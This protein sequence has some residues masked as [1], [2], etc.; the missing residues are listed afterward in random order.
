MFGMNPA[1]RPWLSVLHNNVPVQEV[2]ASDSWDASHIRPTKLGIDHGLIKKKHREHMESGSVYE[3][4]SW[5][6]VIS[7]SMTLMLEAGPIIVREGQCVLIVAG[8]RG[9]VLYHP[10]RVPLERIW[11]SIRGTLCMAYANL[12]LQR[13]GVIQNIG[14][15]ARSVQLAKQLVEQARAVTA[16]PA[17]YWSEQVFHFFNC[18]W[19]DAASQDRQLKVAIT[20]SKPHLLSNSIGSFTKF[21]QRLGYSRSHLTTVLKDHWQDTPGKLIRQSR[22]ERAAELLRTTRRSIADIAVE[23]GYANH[24]SFGRAFARQYA[25][26]P[27]RYRH[28][29][30]HSVP[31]FGCSIEGSAEDNPE[32]RRE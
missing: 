25:K 19:A 1:F 15:D 26:T 31:R 32:H 7:G 9:Q 16:H 22:L 5:Q 20:S 4:I 8:S 27:L 30:D 3:A 17:A 2:A 6:Y 24:Q 21:A 10:S 11:M 14:I 28:D 23:V 13:F 12:L 18:W 29:S